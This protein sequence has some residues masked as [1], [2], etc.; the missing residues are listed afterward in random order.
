MDAHLLKV[1]EVLKQYK[2]SKKGLSS[3]EA[4]RR[5]E[6]QGLNELKAERVAGIIS[7]FLT[8]FKSFLILLL[9]GAA[10]IAFFFGE[11]L[12]GIAI[13]AIIVLNALLGTRQEYKAEK[14]IEA[15]KKTVSLKA[16]VYRDG[17]PT[18]IEAKNLVTGDII[19]IEAGSK[20]P[21]DCR[22]IGSGNIS[23]DQSALTGESALVYKSSKKM[24]K[25]VVLSDRENM[26]FMGTIVATGFAEGIVT[27]TGMDTEIG[28]IAGRIQSIERE[29]PL[30]TKIES[31]ARLLLIIVLLLSALLFTVGLLFGNPI[32]GMLLV[33]ISLAVSAV[34]EGLPAI[35]TIT[36]AMGMVAM[37]KKKAV[38]RKLP[39]VESLGGTTVICSDKTGTLTKN[40]M[41]VT[42]T[43][44]LDE[45]LLVTGTGYSPQGKF[46]LQ[47]KEVAPS[48]SSELLL[49]A[50][51]SCNNA[52]LE[53]RENFWGVVGDPTEG[54]LLVAARKAMVSPETHRVKEL[55]F[56][57]TRKMMSTLHNTSKGFVA[58]TKG[59]PEKVISLCDKVLKKSVSP[60]TE[61]DKTKIS[62]EY[63]R[64]ASNG[65]RVLAVAYKQLGKKDEKIESSLVF[66][67]LIGM[68]DPP[69]DEV[70]HS[71][72]V[73]IDAGIRVVM[74]TGDNK[75]TAEAIS[76]QIGLP[77]AGSITG[78]EIDSISDKKLSKIVSRKVLPIFARVTP[79]HKLRIVEA[80]KR[81]KQVVAVT[82]DG[83]NDAIALKRAD[84]GVS[85]GLRGT[86]VAREASDI[87]LE[88]DN[89]ATIVEAVKEG[90]RI[91]SNILT[92][93]KYLLSVNFSE[94]VLVTVAT[95]AK[96]PLPLLPL[97]ILWINLVTD[98]LPA[99]ALGVDSAEK[100]VM[101]KPP[102]RYLGNPLKGIYSYIIIGGILAFV[103]SFIAYLYGLSTGCVETARTM[104][105]STAIFFELIFVFVIREGKDVFSN[106]Y[107]LFAVGFSVLLQ[108]MVIYVPF[109]HAIFGTASLSVTE[110]MLVFFL[111][112]MALLFPPVKSFVSALNKKFFRKNSFRLKHSV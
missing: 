10:L 65:L 101:F 56:D 35:I 78:A 91:Y 110:I 6:K 12:D 75:D 62:E 111:S 58:Y 96:L 52:F 87:I 14:A 76:K 85:M 57:S 54:A 99:L 45:R 31:I 102:K 19:I 93:I 92:F 22:I 98:G 89:F 8:Q 63:K 24:D 39:A 42:E 1:E 112:L 64:L 81:N 41:T 16:K 95:L 51:A 38:V 29:F 88:D 109:L 59:A 40:E 106:S 90:R 53:E 60:L 30:K 9:L 84:V 73:C 68:Q 17:K 80:F 48:N 28:R 2:T 82:G 5:L 34:P 108:L 47:G 69:R 55:S 83:V 13:T 44:T 77:Y 15:L 21:A 61:E 72:R 7:I 32:I 74:V 3:G 4:A 20:V 33:S 94:I 11:T 25:E 67:G 49:K 46:L 66:L 23:V 104:A 79:D 107:L 37:A 70:P 105:L 26:I 18:I 100:D 86:D 103:S 27:S 71:I 36:L 43:F 97:Q 50:A